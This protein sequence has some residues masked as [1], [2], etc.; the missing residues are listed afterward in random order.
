MRIYI[1]NLISTIGGN[2]DTLAFSSP[3]TL[4]SRYTI[5]AERNNIE[6]VDH[7]EGEQ[8]WECTSYPFVSVHAAYTNALNF[9][10]YGG[11]TSERSSETSKRTQDL[12]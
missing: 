4:H 5:K 1:N 12:A 7:Y 11:R 10:V 8:V 9:S 2:E 6:R 3:Y